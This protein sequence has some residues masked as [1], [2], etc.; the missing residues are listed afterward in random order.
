[1]SNRVDFFQSDQTQLAFPSATVSILLDGSLCPYLE[2]IEMWFGLIGQ[3]LKHPSV[4]SAIG[5]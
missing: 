4:M 5:R 2:L 3:G 1:M